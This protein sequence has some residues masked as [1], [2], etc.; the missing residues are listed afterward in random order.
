MANIFAD[1]TTTKQRFNVSNALW[2]LA[3]NV[4]R[5]NKYRLVGAIVLVLSALILSWLFSSQSSPLH[6]YFLYH[7]ALPNL[8]AAINAVPYVFAIVTAP[9]FMSVGLPEATS[10]Y[11]GLFLQWFF[12]GWLLAGLIFKPIAAR[13]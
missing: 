11:I 5:L 10:G 6:K 2:V 1:G 8:W 12:I 3:L 13:K 9:I 7:V 4:K